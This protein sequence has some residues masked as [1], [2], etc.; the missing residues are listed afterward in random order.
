[1][2]SL[3][4]YLSKT[5]EIANTLRTG[6]DDIESSVGQEKARLGYDQKFKDLEDANKQVL[7]TRRALGGIEGNVKNRLTGRNI[8]NAQLQR[9]TS[10]ERDPL[11]RQLGEST[12]SAELAR[13]NYQGIL[14]AI[15]E[16]RQNKRQ[17]LT[18]RVTGLQTEADAFRNEYSAQDALEA[19]QAQEKFNNDMLAIQRLQFA[20][21][22]PKPSPTAIE[23][24]PTTP[25]VARVEIDDGGDPVKGFTTAAQNAIPYWQQVL[26]RGSNAARAGGGIN[27]IGILAGGKSIW[28]DSIGR[29]L[30]NR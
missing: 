18:D 28:D 25:N 1:M 11:S 24:K 15:N 19:R 27:P 2:A 17:G 26:Q 7:E 20:P 6:Q 13:G 12:G 22:P 30:G 5:G 14:D 4:K 9:I 21:P 29:I 10:A 8:T 23:P 16:F 3:D